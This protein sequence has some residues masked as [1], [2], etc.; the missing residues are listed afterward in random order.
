[1]GYLLAWSSLFPIFI[2]ISFLTLVAVRRDL[3]TVREKRE[4]MEGIN[5]QGGAV[6]A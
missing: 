6:I 3:F 5:V 2:L 4:I 1:M